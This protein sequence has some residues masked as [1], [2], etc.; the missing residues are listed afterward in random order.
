MEVRI[1]VNG[2]LVRM[3]FSDTDKTIE[4]CLMRILENLY[5]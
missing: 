1:K 4:D 3:N 2:K 5:K